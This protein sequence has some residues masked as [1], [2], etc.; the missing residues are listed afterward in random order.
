MLKLQQGKP[1]EALGLLSKAVAIRP[2]A[3]EALGNLSAVLLVSIGRRGAPLSASR[4]T[5]NRGDLSGRKYSRGMARRLG[6]AAEAPGELQPG[7]G[8]QADHVDACSIAPL[9]AA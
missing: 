6:R 5:I 3:L 1:D 2:S 9:L 4:S 8:D 7:V